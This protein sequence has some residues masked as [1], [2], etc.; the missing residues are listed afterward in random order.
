MNVGVSAHITGAAQGGPRYDASVTPEQRADIANA[1]WLCQ[2]CAKLIDNDPCRFT[3]EVL[4]EWKE[5]AEQDALGLVG[6]TASSREDSA[7]L[8]DKWVS[9]E[10]IEKAGIT[11]KLAG[12]GYDLHWTRADN[13][14]VKVDLE[15]WEPVVVSQVDGTLARLKVQDSPI[16]GGYLILLKKRKP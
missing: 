10:Y 2:N 14:S 5:K 8:V 3:A 4:R 13:E 12:Q 11:T 9:V 6:K 15:G 16:I 1:I 7:T